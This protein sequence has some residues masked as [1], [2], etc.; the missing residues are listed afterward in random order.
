MAVSSGLEALEPSCL[1]YVQYADVCPLRDVCY[2]AQI[3]RALFRSGID[4]K[5]DVLEL[6]VGVA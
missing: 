4:R 2:R 6:G 3:S 5:H 1:K